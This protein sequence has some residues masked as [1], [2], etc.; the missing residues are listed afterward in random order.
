[1]GQN[2]KL[3]VPVLSQ[4]YM[5]MNMMQGNNSLCNVANRIRG[6]SGVAKQRSGATPETLLIL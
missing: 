5:V 2:K 6:V 4:T 3:K 1:M